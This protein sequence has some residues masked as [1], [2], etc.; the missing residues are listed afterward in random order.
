MATYRECYKSWLALH[1]AG[2][3]DS[4]SL[5]SEVSDA[6]LARLGRDAGTSDPMEIELPAICSNCL[7]YLVNGQYER[8][9]LC[10]RSEDVVLPNPTPIEV[11]TP[12]SVVNVPIETEN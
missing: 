10:R 9:C 4:G 11:S 5:P 2:T 12:S 8:E 6:V 3:W 1:S 7:R